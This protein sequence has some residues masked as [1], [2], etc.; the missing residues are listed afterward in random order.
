M[1]ALSDMFPLARSP[2]RCDFGKGATARLAGQEPPK[3]EDNEA[4]FDE[5]K[6]RIAKTLD[7]CEEFK[8]VQSTAP[9]S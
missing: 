3:Y 1:P 2:D 4:S 6:A 8:A 5:L 9:R 7:L